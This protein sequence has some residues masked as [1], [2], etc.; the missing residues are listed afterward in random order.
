MEKNLLGWGGEISIHVSKTRPL[1]SKG[2]NSTNGFP[3][4]KKTLRS[5]QRKRFFFFQKRKAKVFFRRIQMKQGK[6]N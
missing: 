1:L 6:G 4:K 5:F 2:D 3:N